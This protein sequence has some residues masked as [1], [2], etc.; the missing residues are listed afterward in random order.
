M[1]YFSVD[2]WVK[3][4]KPSNKPRSWRE[5]RKFREAQ[6]FEIITGFP[7]LQGLDIWNHHETHLPAF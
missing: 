3:I 6:K 7:D 5:A 4:F 2:S 1:N